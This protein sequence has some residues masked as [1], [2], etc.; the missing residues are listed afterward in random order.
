MLAETLLA[1]GPSAE[2]L[3]DG[4]ECRHL[5]AHLVL[6]E[7][8][9]LAA[10][11]AGGPLEKPMM[12]LLDKWADEARSI[13]GYQRL[14]ERFAAGPGSFSPFAIGRVER[15]ANLTEFFV[16]TEDIRRAHERWAPR[17]LDREYSERLWSALTRVS[18][19]LYRG[20]DV[21]VIL[22][23]PDGKRHVAKKANTS[24]AI[25]G[26]PSELLMHGSGRR[27]HALVTFE[28]TDDAVALLSD[29]SVSR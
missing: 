19:L 18:S 17:V 1:A 14:V 2:T 16:H 9:A 5:A 21:G 15:A 25:T 6:R 10:G 29:V 7:H 13:P 12:R 27:D 24:V 11:I 20:V 8:H 26:E 23:R 4:W 22:V 28:G 3:C